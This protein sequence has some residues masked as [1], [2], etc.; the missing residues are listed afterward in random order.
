M[1]TRLAAQLTAN[2]SITQILGT[3][4]KRHNAKSICALVHHS[5]YCVYQGCD[6]F[7]CGKEYFL[8]IIDLIFL[9]LRHC[10]Q[11]LFQNI[12]RI[13][14][15]FVPA[16]YQVR[17]EAD[18]C[19]GIALFGSCSRSNHC[20]PIWPTFFYKNCPNILAIL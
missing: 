14:K 6:T 20:N 13:L 18:N 15:I 3:V 4:R 7:P 9:I 10:L 11:M 8:V 5:H 1:S 19:V 12:Y 17:I 16:S 2:D